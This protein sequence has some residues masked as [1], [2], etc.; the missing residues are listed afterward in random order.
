MFKMKFFSLS[1][2]SKRP[3]MYW[4]L[5]IRIWIRLE[6]SLYCR[7]G[8]VKFFLDPSGSLD[9]QHWELGSLSICRKN[10][11]ERTIKSGWA[12]WAGRWPS[13]RRWGPL[14][15]PPSRPGT[16][17]TRARAPAPAPRRATGLAS[18][19]SN[20]NLSPFVFFAFIWLCAKF[21]RIKPKKS[22]SQ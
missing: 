8:S 13:G 6:R 10:T 12:P 9:L 15:G 4:L 7:S 19:V 11:H 14:P 22:V 17:T 16:A 1:F 2:L 5:C 3:D 21:Y 20:T 18:T